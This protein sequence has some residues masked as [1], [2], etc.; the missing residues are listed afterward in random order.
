MGYICDL[1]LEP[2]DGAGPHPP[3][4]A[5][6]AAING[7]QTAACVCPNQTEAGTCHATLASQGQQRKARP[8]TLG[9]HFYKGLHFY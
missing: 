7:R 4:G 5:P 2:P 6:M 3:L 9:Q 1:Q 8:Q